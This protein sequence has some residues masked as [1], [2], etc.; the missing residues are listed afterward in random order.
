VANEKN[1]QKLKWFLEELSLIGAIANCSS[2]QQPGLRCG[3][4]IG[5]AKALFEAKYVNK[6]S[7]NFN[8]TL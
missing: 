6:F 1:Q 3:A 5:A 2:Y 4:N 7:N 8:I